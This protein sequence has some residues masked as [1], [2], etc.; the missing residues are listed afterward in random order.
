VL[1]CLPKVTRFRVDVPL[2]SGARSLALLLIAYE[3]G[4][5]IYG[6]ASDGAGH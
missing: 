2:T 5:G 6:A 1:Y 4:T 3:V